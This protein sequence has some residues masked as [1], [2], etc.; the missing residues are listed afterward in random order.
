M[1]QFLTRYGLFSEI[2]IS[3]TGFMVQTLPNRHVL[4]AVSLGAILQI[5]SAD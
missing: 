2:Q 1:F 3:P 4:R 5:D